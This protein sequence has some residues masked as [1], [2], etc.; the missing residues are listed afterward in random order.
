MQK[1]NKSDAS[2]DFKVLYVDDEPK[3][4]KY[5]SKV[6]GSYFE[7]L[8][9][10]SVASAIEV[11]EEEAP[12]IGVIITDQRMPNATGVD[13]LKQTRTR[14]PEIVTVLL[15]AYTDIDDAIA[16]IN[17]GRI[18]QYI[19]KPWEPDKL[20]IKLLEA[21]HEYSRN[22]YNLKLAELNKQLET[23][24]EVQKDFINMLSHEVRTPIG[25]SIN[26]A[27]Q[28]LETPL[29]EEQK[30][31]IASIKIVNDNLANILDNTLDYSKWT[32][33]TLTLS[34][35]NFRLDELLDQLSRTFKLQIASSE[36]NYTCTL[37]N[38][39]DPALRGDPDRLLQV[40]INLVSNAIKFT[41]KGGNVSVDTSLI[42]ENEKTVKLRFAVK[43]TGSGIAPEVLD[44]LFK[45]FSQAKPDKR[46][47][48][49]GLSISRELVSM[50]GGEIGTL[51]ELKQGSEFWFS[52]PFGRQTPEETGISFSEP[53]KVE[54]IR[55]M[56]ADDNVINRV[57][58]EDL[59]S[60]YGYKV[61]AAENG[62]QALAMAS[63]N[64]YSVIIM[65]FQMPEM[66][67]L[68]AT[69]RIRAN[70][71]N[72]STPIIALSAMPESMVAGQW[73]KAGVNDFISKPFERFDFLE[74]IH[75]WIEKEKV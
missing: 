9:A 2:Q 57:M 70:G 66:D 18:F 7:V 41:P 62:D 64:E 30:D 47:T 1:Q 33:G 51:S 31:H 60:R 16:A 24:N 10:E 11:L 75:Y 27:D 23:A 59:L 29:S 56:L 13:L 53:S 71:L 67:G 63:Q 52:I 73:E 37:D 58:V 72:T 25:V 14:W 28:L 69:R 55:V 19:K 48:G 74:K 36:L 34:Y 38:E 68:E 42:E 8:T 22:Q 39:I 61:E 15:T 20:K 5:F 32:A 44:N 21:I 3:A 35:M 46:G 45:P 4:L 65:D 43:D 49:L 6:F 40:L 17:E 54:N 12:S 26:L 50:M